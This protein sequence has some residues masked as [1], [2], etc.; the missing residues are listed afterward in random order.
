MSGHPVKSYRLDFTDWTCNKKVDHGLS[1]TRPN[2]CCVKSYGITKTFN[3]NPAS[4]EQIKRVVKKSKVTNTGTVTL[5]VEK[6]T[7]VT[8]G[9]S[10]IELLPESEIPVPDNSSELTIFYNHAVDAGQCRVRITID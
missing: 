8:Q 1:L 3:I 5:W 9:P 2:F 4:Y 10:A 6:G 7:I